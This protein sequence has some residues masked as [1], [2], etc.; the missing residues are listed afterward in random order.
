MPRKNWSSIWLLL[1]LLASP[2]I[3]E[4]YDSST[5]LLVCGGCQTSADYASMAKSGVGARTGAFEFLVANPDIN[6]VYDVK[7]QSEYDIELRRYHYIVTYNQETPPDAEQAFAFFYPYFSKS[8]QIYAEAPRGGGE[9][10]NGFRVS[11]QGAVCTAFTGTAGF[12]EL[13]NQMNTGSGSILYKVLNQYF[14]RGPTGIYVFANG[15]VATY[16]IYP[17][18]PGITACKYVPG[19]ARDALGSFINDRGLGGTGASDGNPYVRNTG[20]DRFN[21]IGSSFGLVCSYVLNPD[22]TRSLIGCYQ[23]P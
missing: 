13:H 16:L 12:V 17:D 14:G 5:P 9:G 21:I 23:T 6:K 20:P 18:L 11:D 2:K 1:I 15:D 8:K 10:L 22:G 3:S 7:V 4:A 19:T